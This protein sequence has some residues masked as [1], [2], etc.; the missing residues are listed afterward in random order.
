MLHAVIKVDLDVLVGKVVNLFLVLLQLCRLILE[1]LLLLGQ[2]HALGCAGAV[3][4][5]TKLGKLGAVTL[6][7]LMHIVGAQT[8]EK[9]SLI[10]VH[11][12]QRLETVLL[13]AVKEPVDWALLIGF[14][15]VS[16]EVIQE[17]AADHLAGRTLAAE[18]AGNKFEVFFQRIITIDLTDKLHKTSGNVIVKILVIADGDDVVAVRQKPLTAIYS[19]G[20]AIWIGRFICSKLKIIYIPLFSFLTL[21][22]SA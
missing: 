19:L 12:A 11:I 1:L 9:I 20:I 8:G 16:V 17:V 2:L 14:Q 15:V 13:T 22:D 6:L 18:R 21:A 10:A 7:L 3:D 5:V 4:G